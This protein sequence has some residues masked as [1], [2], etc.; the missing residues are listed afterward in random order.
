MKKLVAVITIILGLFETINAQNFSQ[1]TYRTP[2]YSN[3]NT[4]VRTSPSSYSTNQTYSSPKSYTTVNTSRSSLGSGNYSSSTNVFSK[5]SPRST[6]YTTST[7]TGAFTVTSTA[8]YNSCGSY[9]G[10]TSRTRKNSNW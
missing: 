5:S 10:T 9:T 6:S 8:W 3:Y 4:T 1:S 2:S 7:N